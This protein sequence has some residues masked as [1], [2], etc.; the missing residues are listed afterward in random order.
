M[1]ASKRSIFKCTSIKIEISKVHR[2][3]LTEK[4]ENLKTK[5]FILKVNRRK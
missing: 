5:M 1:N 4:I 3:K 2:L